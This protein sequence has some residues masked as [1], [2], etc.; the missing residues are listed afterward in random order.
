VGSDGPRP[1]EAPTCGYSE[2]GRILL[3]HSDKWYQRQ[4]SEKPEKISLGSHGDGG[5]RERLRWVTRMV[6]T[7]ELDLRSG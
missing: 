6:V 5:A 1:S 2:S 4:K 7:G 3:H